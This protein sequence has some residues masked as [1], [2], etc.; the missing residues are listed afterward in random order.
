MFAFLKPLTKFRVAVDEQFTLLITCLANYSDSELSLSMSAQDK[1][2]SFKNR[3]LERSGYLWGPQTQL[4]NQAKVNLEKILFFSGDPKNQHRKKAFFFSSFIT[5]LRVCSPG[6]FT[7]LW[8]IASELMSED[9]IDF[10]LTKSRTGLIENVA[11]KF[12][13]KL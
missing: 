13:T 4:Y 1:L 5:Q 10:L 6:T 11:E 8:H 2:E 7:S 12:F 9:S 3:Y